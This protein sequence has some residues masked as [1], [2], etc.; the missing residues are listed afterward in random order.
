MKY[1]LYSILLFSV[2][3]SIAQES[4]SGN[5]KQILLDNTSKGVLNKASRIN[6]GK[7]KSQIKSV[8]HFFND[9]LEIELLHIRNGEY[10]T[11]HVSLKSKEENLVNTYEVDYDF[12]DSFIDEIKIYN[13]S[14]LFFTINLEKHKIWSSNNQKGRSLSQGILLFKVINNIL[15][16]KYFKES[17]VRSG[18]DY[19]TGSFDEKIFFQELVIVKGGVEFINSEND[20]RKYELHGSKLSFTEY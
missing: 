2:N 12:N 10:W 18:V 16:Y 11:Y 3:Y 6:Q 8:A 17:V 13:S 14:D 1:F 4:D 20:V 9:T 7:K 5:P 19:R 15:Y